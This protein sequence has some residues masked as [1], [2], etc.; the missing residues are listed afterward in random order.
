MLFDEK[1]RTNTYIVFYAEIHGEIAGLAG[2]SIE[3][4]RV[5]EIGVDVKE[6]YRKGGLASVLVNHLKHD[7]LERY[8]LPIYCVASSNAASQATAFRAGLKPCWISTYKIY[9]MGVRGM[10]SWCGGCT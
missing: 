2:A 6:R 9:W 1:G 8:I 5:W 4:G 3:S 7:I 10:M